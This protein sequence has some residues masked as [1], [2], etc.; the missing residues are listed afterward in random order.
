LA[1]PFYSGHR[2]ELVHTCALM[3]KIARTDA[4]SQPPVELRKMLADG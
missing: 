4:S 3:R 1:A 2:P